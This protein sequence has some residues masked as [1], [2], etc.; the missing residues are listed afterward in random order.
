MLRV[1]RILCNILATALEF[2]TLASGILQVKR[3]I[4]TSTLSVS[5]TSSGTYYQIPTASF[6]VSITPQFAN[7]VILLLGSIR[8]SETTATGPDRMRIGLF[9]D[10]TQIGLNTDSVG[11]RFSTISSSFNTDPGELASGE[12]IYID[13]PNTTSAINYNF[14]MGSNTSSVTGY[15]NRSSGSDGDSGGT[16]RGVS[17]IIAIEL[18]NGIL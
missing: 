8:H 12:V 6:S 10:S 4:F 3:T 5:I 9:R 16:T 15:L 17:S 7:S 14:K 13:S 1:N 2:G 11:S 18:A